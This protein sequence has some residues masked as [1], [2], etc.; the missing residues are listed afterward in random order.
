MLKREHDYRY[1][2]PKQ[3][4]K[5]YRNESKRFLNHLGFL[6]YCWRMLGRRES[7]LLSNSEILEELGGSFSTIKK[8]DDRLVADGVIEKRQGNWKTKKA[9][10]YRLLATDFTPKCSERT[11]EGSEGK[12]VAREEEKKCSESTDNNS[13]ETETVMEKNE[14]EKIEKSVARKNEE[15]CSTYNM[16]DSCMKKSINTSQK[17]H[18]SVPCSTNS[19]EES[20]STESCMKEFTE[21]SHSKELVTCGENTPNHQSKV[22]QFFT[23]E[24]L[25]GYN[26]KLLS[27]AP[28]YQLDNLT[29][30]QMREGSEWLWKSWNRYKETVPTLQQTYEEVV[31]ATK[32]YYHLVTVYYSKREKAVERLDSML[33]TETVFMRSFIRNKWNNFLQQVREGVYD[34]KASRKTKEEFDK[35]TEVWF[36]YKEGVDKEDNLEAVQYKM[37]SDYTEVW[38]GMPKE[39]SMSVVDDL[40]VAGEPLENIFQYLQGSGITKKQIRE[41]WN[42]F[43]TVTTEDEDDIPVV[44]VKRR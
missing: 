40:I 23:F 24:R 26:E 6:I 42:T 29:F 41:R 9:N 21:A 31:Q 12:S 18:V 20:S 28:Y 14:E 43:H 3:L 1:T 2:V 27:K 15:K 34:S 16:L 10:E 39:A 7:F 8:Y 22:E 33:K 19:V 13:T 44:T 36:S 17:V 4:R 25:E 5:R 35:V 32:T 37:N 11:D 30:Q 38:L